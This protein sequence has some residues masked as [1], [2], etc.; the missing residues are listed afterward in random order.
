ARLPREPL[1]GGVAFHVVLRSAK[2]VVERLQTE[3]GALHEDVRSSD[4]Q[5][6]VVQQGHRLS[7]PGCRS[8]LELNLCDRTQERGPCQ[9]TF[10]RDDPR[11][12]TR[13]AADGCA[14][15][16]ETTRSRAILPASAA[17]G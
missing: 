4:I 10:L 14:E 6:L 2:E 15:T 5:V 17:P 12:L 1:H 7:R 16:G 8:R 13:N 9:R 11:Q 3:E